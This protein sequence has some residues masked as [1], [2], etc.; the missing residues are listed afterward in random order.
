MYQRLDKSPSA[1][2]NLGRWSGGSELG[3]LS[4]SCDKKSM[5]NKKAASA[6]LKRHFFL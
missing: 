5:G 1:S 6:L 2:N 4:K 3:T